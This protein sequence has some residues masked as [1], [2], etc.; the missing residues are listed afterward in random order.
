[1]RVVGIYG[2]YAH[3]QEFFGGV[4]A[5]ARRQ[6]EYRRVDLSEFFDLSDIGDVYPGVLRRNIR[7]VGLD[8]DPRFHV[9]GILQR[10]QNAFA[11][12]SEADDCGL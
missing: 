4:R 2:V 8:D 6:G 7:A 9:G 5:E 3:V 11:D 1:V 12:V 10:V